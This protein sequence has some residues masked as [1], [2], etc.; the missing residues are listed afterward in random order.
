MNLENTLMALSK[1][2][3]LDPY[4]IGLA[5]EMITEAH[6]V[7]FN[8]VLTLTIKSTKFDFLSKLQE[9]INTVSEE[10]KPDKNKIE[11]YCKTLVDKCR[12]ISLNSYNNKPLNLDFDKWTQVAT[13]ECFK[14]RDCGSP[15]FNSKEVK[16]LDYIGGCK[17]WLKDYDEHK[18]LVKLINAVNTFNSK[19]TKQLAYDKNNK[20]IQLLN[21]DKN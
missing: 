19:D 20:V 18:F 21:G 15:A 9:A 4:V 16:L 6:I 2:Y 11:D 14:L 5:K 1:N 7:D 8:R 13:Y 10:M 3:R 12:R 17:V